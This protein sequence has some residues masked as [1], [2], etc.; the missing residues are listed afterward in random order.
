VY[1]NFKRCL[2]G[3]ARDLWDQINVIEEEEEEVRDKLTFD[4]HLKELTSAILGDDALRNQKDYLKNTPEPDKM[5][6]KQWINRIKNI[7]SYLP[8][9]QPNGRSFTKEDL[10]AEVITENIPSAWVKDFK[11]F[12]LHLKTKIK[13]FISELTVI[14]EQIK[15]HHK[16]SQDNPSKKHLKNPYRVHNGGHEWDYCRQNPKNQKTDDKNQNN[17]GG[18]GGNGNNNGR[19]REEQRRTKN[20]HPTSREQSRSN[21]RSSEDEDEIYVIHNCKKEEHKKEKTVP[22]AKILVAIPDKKGS[23]KYKT[24]LGLVDSGSPVH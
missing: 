2:A 13:D 23:R 19:T 21:S 4:N 20:N 16:N 12:K 9:M 7:N 24:Y 22:S 18:R 1:Q 8:L 10:I 14:E 6:V 3:A 11:M 5:T 17:G 15:T